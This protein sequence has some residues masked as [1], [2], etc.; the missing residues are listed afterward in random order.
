[1]CSPP[2]PGRSRPSSNRPCDGCNGPTARRRFFTPRA[3]RRACAARST[4]TPAGQAQKEF[5]VN[6][7]HAL[8]DALLHCAIEG[9]ANA[10]PASP[11]E[12]AA[13]LV[14]TAPTGDWSGQAGK[15]ACRQGGGWLFVAPRDGLRVLNRATGQDMRFSGAWKVPTRPAAPS[16]GAVI[17]AEA[18]ASLAAILTALESAG[19]IPPA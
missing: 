14:G 13:W 11:A 5:F 9:V 6:E 7:A 15:L 8:T 16:G 4:A 18:R 17:D 1:M 2:P 19:M 10:P 12:G 3:S